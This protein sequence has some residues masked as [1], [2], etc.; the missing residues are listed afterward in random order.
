M[1]RKND[2]L[3]FYRVLVDIIRQIKIKSHSLLFIV[4]IITQAIGFN[5]VCH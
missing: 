5:I 1:V 4:T 3:S 2:S